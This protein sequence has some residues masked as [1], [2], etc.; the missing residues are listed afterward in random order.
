VLAGSNGTLGCDAE[1]RREARET[2][3]R[4]SPLSLVI[5]P[6]RVAVKS[7]VVSAALNDFPRFFQL[8]APSHREDRYRSTSGYGPLARRDVVC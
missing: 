8:F 5:T 6:C 2:Q 1:L 4:D 3:R 7:D